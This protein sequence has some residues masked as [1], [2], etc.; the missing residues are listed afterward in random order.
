MPIE[1]KTKLES[2]PVT[3]QSRRAVEKQK[4]SEISVKEKTGWRRDPHLPPPP[5]HTLI[6]H[7][8]HALHKL[9]AR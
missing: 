8:W 9:R 4:P 6:T 5:T 2:L 7:R 1:V 3:P